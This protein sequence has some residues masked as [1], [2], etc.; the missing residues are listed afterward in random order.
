[1][2]PNAAI[3]ISRMTLASWIQ[4]CASSVRPPANKI[5]ASSRSLF[6]EV[7]RDWYCEVGLWNMILGRIAPG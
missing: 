5:S 4:M 3:K 7:G 1:M 2:T 6:E